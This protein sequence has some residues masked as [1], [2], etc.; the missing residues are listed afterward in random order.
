MTLVPKALGSAAQR[1]VHAVLPFQV[2]HLGAPAKL[3]FWGSLLAM[4]LSAV[5]NWS[6]GDQSMYLLG[7]VHCGVPHCGLVFLV[8][9]VAVIFWTYILNLICRDGH[10]MLAWVL[11]AV[12]LLGLLG[13]VSAKQQY[14]AEA[15]KNRPSGQSL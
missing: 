6:A 8:K 7:P 12:P 9:L 11:V 4:A 14:D 1:S 13:V 10:T 5:H 3:Y 15:F 2:H